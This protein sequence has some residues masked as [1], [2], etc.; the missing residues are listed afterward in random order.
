MNIDAVCMFM[1]NCI[2]FKAEECTV[3][4]KVI[5]SV[6]LLYQSGYVIVISHIFVILQNL[7]N[8]T[9][10]STYDSSDLL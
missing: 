1:S 9:F 6:Y 4:H 5:R 3:L 7:L 10:V 2:E 8:L